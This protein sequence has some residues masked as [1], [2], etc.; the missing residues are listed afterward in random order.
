MKILGFGL[1]PNNVYSTKYRLSNYHSFFKKNGIKL[2]IIP[3][4]Q[5]SKFEKLFNKNKFLGNLF[6]Y[7]FYLSTIIIDVINSKKYDF[8]F[9]QR[10]LFP[11]KISFLEKL[12]IKMNPNII[13]DFDDAIFSLPKHFRY[14]NWKKDA[15]ARNEFNKVKLLI[16]NSKLVIAGND[17]LKKY[18]QKYNNNVIVVP[19]PIDVELF[20]KPKKNYSINNSIKIGWYGS[21]GN[22]PYLE[23]I[24]DAIKKIKNKYNIKLVV[25][26][27]KPYYKDYDFIENIKWDEKK[28]ETQITKLD[29]AVA[30][31]PKDEWTRGKCGY[32]IMKYMICGVPCIVTPI[33]IQK[34]II[35]DG[36]NGYH[37][38]NIE[39]WIKCIEKLIKSKKNRKDFGEKSR[40]KV[41]DFYSREFLGEKI[42]KSIY[43]INRSK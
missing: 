12:L 26:S 42:I 15:N 4:I 7:G 31:L 37:A 11:G 6:Y 3:I 27:D 8:V 23:S 1:D 36:I 43:Q 32:K 39:E 21:W 35:D 30:P 33:E 41:S 24:I 22:Q 25:I 29:M 2:K 5:I 16:K 38:N 14:K 28:E 34:E 13:F 20:K 10:H 19:T 18:A 17:Y 40:K 9:I